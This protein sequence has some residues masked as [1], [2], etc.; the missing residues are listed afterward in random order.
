MSG[1]SELNNT[2]E[3][4][5]NRWLQPN[6]LVFYFTLLAALLAFKGLGLNDFWDDEANTAVIGRN[7]LKTG[8]LTA[9]DGRN[10]L[11]YGM[12]GQL[13]EDMKKLT[14]PPLQYVVAAAGLWFFGD[15]TAGIRFFFVLIGLLTVPFA[16][17]WYRHEFESKS[18][19]LAGFLLAV[20]VPFLLYIRQVR[21]Y[22]L[23]LA[24]SFATL[25][26]WSSISKGKNAPARILAG[27]LFFSLLI[28][29]Q[30]LYSIAT[31][32]I[33]FLSLV[34]S[35]YRCGVNFV[36][37]GLLTALSLIT[38]LVIDHYYSHSLLR[39]YGQGNFWATRATHF[40]KLIPMVSVD[41]LRFELMPAG[42][43]L[44]AWAGY[45]LAG[46]KGLGYIKNIGMCL[47]YC[48]IAIVVITWCSPQPV[49]NAKFA[50]MRYYVMLI[51][52]G[53]CM[54]AAIFELFHSSCQKT[55]KIV[56]LLTP[57]AG[58][59]KAFNLKRQYIATFFLIILV[60]SNVLTLNFILQGG[61]QFRWV[62]Y[63]R[64]IT[65]DYKTGS[66]AIGEFLE[67]N[68]S[69]NEC[70]F[71]APLP[72]NIIQMYYHPDYKFCG[73]VTSEAAFARK[74][75]EVLR[76]DLFFEKTIPDYFITTGKNSR[77]FVKRLNHIYG[78]GAYELSE[79][80]PVYGGNLTRPE[81][82]LRTFGT[83]IV[84]NPLEHGVLIVKRTRAP[85]YLP[86]ISARQM[87][88]LLEF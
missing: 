54:A 61:L 58:K 33:I 18:Y 19:W 48:L 35:K 59:A 46:E 50:D 2:E 5:E 49:L 87:Q 52:L 4:R 20:N 27:I 23:G 40:L 37:L 34:R 14:H 7:L 80:L 79:I 47:A 67:K 81:I 86:R 11:S 88:D 25:W 24:F 30:P 39:V 9:W 16:A 84:Q 29:S 51:P 13:T 74:N 12:G 41:S 71:M 42:M 44:F 10:L 73:L 62:Q 22:P 57:I 55:P 63:I 1:N 28:I 56:F 76:E 78:P 72:M 45:Y 17:A 65:V 60:F 69:K 43:F 64:E 8:E 26:I 21:Y 75:R 53:S 68:V 83:L 70:V 38:L 3:I 36:F 66:E 77:N 6:A 15:S 31:L 82:L 32:A 85:A